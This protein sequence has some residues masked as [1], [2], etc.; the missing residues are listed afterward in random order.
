[1]VASASAKLVVANYPVSLINV[2]FSVLFWG[3][4]LQSVS[5]DAGMRQ[6][7]HAA[8]LSLQVYDHPYKAFVDG[9]ETD[10]LMEIDPNRRIMTFR[11]GNGSKEIVEVHDFKNVSTKKSG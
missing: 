7:L 2:Q 3:F 9:V 5:A 10:S 1:M 11:T 8:P 6:S 4:F